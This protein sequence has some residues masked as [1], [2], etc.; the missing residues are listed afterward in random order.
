VIGNLYLKPA[1]GN[2]SYQCDVVNMGG[3]VPVHAD[4]CVTPLHRSEH[5]REE[6]GGLIYIHHCMLYLHCAIAI[7]S[8]LCA[9]T[10]SNQVTVN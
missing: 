1:C 7:S 6:K 3:H 4:K 2:I 5:N 9:C 8:P 10:S